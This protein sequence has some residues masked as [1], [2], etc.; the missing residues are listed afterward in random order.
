MKRVTDYPAWQQLVKHC[1][2]TSA[3]SMRDLFIAEPD[4]FDSLSV[5]VDDLLFDYSKNRIDRQGI[6]LLTALARDADVEA[7]RDAMFR[8]EA[9]NITE[10]RAA[11]H[12]ALRRPASDM[13][14]V[15]GRDIVKDIIQVR[16]QMDS[17]STRLFNGDYKGHTGKH[18]TDVVN[19]G[20]GGSDLGPAMVCEALSPY[21]DT[22]I[23]VHF[24][25]NIDPADLLRTL[26]NLDAEHTLFIIASKSFT[27]LET[28]ANAHAAR[29]W[30][31]DNGGTTS[32]ASKHFVAVSGNPAK[33]AEFGIVPEN[34]FILWDFVGG[35]YSLWSAIGLPIVIAVGMQRFEALLD[36]AYRMDQ[37]FLSAPIT[38]NMPMLLAL[39]GIY[40]RNFL[41]YRG[42][43]ITPYDHNLGRFAEHIQQL[44]MESNG[45]S[46]DVNGRRI[47]DYDT[48]PILL[49]G[50]GTNAQH[51][52][53]QILHQGSD[54]IPVDFL[55]AAN[56][57]YPD[58]NRHRELM[59]NCLA[60]SEALMTGRNVDETRQAMGDHGIE[61][62]DDAS[63]NHR[64]FD[65]N[66]P[67]NTL[68]YRRLDPHTLG[69]L[70]ALYEHKVFV[71]GVIWNINSFDQFG[72]ELGKE[73]AGKINTDLDEQKSAG[74]ESTRTKAYD[75]STRGLIDHLRLL[76]D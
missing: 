20:I 47:D 2:A 71:E 48:G 61:L 15:D 4:R 55:I 64:V 73:L 22:G 23:N 14:V 41:G 37:H 66:R 53:F 62:N 25:S 24:V 59:A 54:V 18:I 8:G 3:M 10:Q 45:K 57:H 63:I 70:I 7:R 65:G 40:N 43:V 42:Q 12:T 27:T 9:I 13:L 75:A 31:L 72:V 35:R 16:H 39:A 69:M 32:G 51:S 29:R 11:L 28:L 46:V 52:Y 6:S 56:S 33:V 44:D 76:K 38:D 19:I 60:Q 50:T 30:F 21:R 26:A 1:D 49:G 34:H 74:V 67:S 58:T 68:A 36:G 5:R 17:F